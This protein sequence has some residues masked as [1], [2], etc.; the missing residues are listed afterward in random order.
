[1]GL[2]TAYVVSNGLVP[3]DTDKDG[4]AD[5]KDANSDNDAKSDIAER[6]D[7]KPVTLSGVLDTDKDGL[8][9]LFEGAS[10]SDGYVVADSNLAAPNLLGRFSAASDYFFRDKDHTP[11]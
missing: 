5:F 11:L 10:V 9:D 7:A 8:L 6:G 2:D 3:V 4:V 1:M